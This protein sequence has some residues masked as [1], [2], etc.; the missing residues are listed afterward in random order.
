[1]SESEKSPP[2]VFGIRI[3][4][5]DQKIE[6]KERQGR[7]K[8]F[9]SKEIPTDLGMVSLYGDNEGEYVTDDGTAQAIFITREK[10]LTATAKDFDPDESPFVLDLQVEPS[11]GVDIICRMAYPKENLILETLL[12]RINEEFPGESFA[13]STDN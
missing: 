8:S 9:Q 10:V 4:S 12:A 3:F 11:P 5:P 6:I 7:D 2:S 1:M 13:Q